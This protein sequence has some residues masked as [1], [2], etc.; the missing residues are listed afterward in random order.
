ML[1]FD[2]RSRV[3]Q[4]AAPATSLR[5]VHRVDG[6]QELTG[7]NDAGV[8]QDGPATVLEAKLIGADGPPLRDPIREARED[9][10]A[11]VFVL[12]AEGRLGSRR[13]AGGA[14][15]LPGRLPTQRERARVEAPRPELAIGRPLF[16]GPLDGVE[17]GQYVRA[18]RL[19]GQLA[20]GRPLGD[21]R[22]DPGGSGPHVALSPLG[23]DAREPRMGG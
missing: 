1:R 7:A 9:T 19:Q 3:H 16:V 11:Q 23:E 5:A 14:L 20:G 18:R 4:D 21:E 13:Q 22:G 12:I 15:E 6:D 17:H 8:R 10:E 2:L